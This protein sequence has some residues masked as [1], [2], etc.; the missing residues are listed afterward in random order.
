MQ[1][2]LIKTLGASGFALLIGVAACGGAGTEPTPPAANSEAAAAAQS[3][4]TESLSKVSQTKPGGKLMNLDS[5]ES[6]A[7]RKRAPK[8][9][10]PPTLRP[11]DFYDGA[12]TAGI[13]YDGSDG[14]YSYWECDNLDACETM[15]ESYCYD[16]NNGAC[17]VYTYPDNSTWGSCYCDGPAF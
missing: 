15:F 9:H 16:D 11:K 12:G 3:R 10:H 2:R 13:T 17:Y 8:G 4:V 5:W 1:T 14:T 7:G 6:L